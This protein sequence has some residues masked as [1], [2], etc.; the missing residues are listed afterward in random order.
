MGPPQWLVKNFSLNYSL[1][2]DFLVCQ[3]PLRFSFPP[4]LNEDAL[5][6]GAEQ[7]SLAVLKSGQC[8]SEGSY[9]TLT[10]AA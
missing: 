7:L 5:M 10:Q 2:D 4:E 9:G 6:Q 1:T 3:N 8:K